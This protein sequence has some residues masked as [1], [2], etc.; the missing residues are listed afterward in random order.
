MIVKELRAQLNRFADDLDV[1]VLV[2][3]HPSGMGGPLIVEEFLPHALAEGQGFVAIE[4]E[5]GL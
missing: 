5:E 4:C 1:I 2:R 3:S